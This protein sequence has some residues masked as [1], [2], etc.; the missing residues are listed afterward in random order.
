MEGKEKAKLK[1]I[2]FGLIY[3][4]GAKLTSSKII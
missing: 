3:G 1:Q 2:A 4:I